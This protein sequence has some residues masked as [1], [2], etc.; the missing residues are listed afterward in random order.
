[1]KEQP[2]KH[3]LKAIKLLQDNAHQ[4]RSIHEQIGS[5]LADIRAQ[6]EA[7]GAE[8]VEFTEEHSRLK[9]RNIELMS[10]Y[11][12]LEA[13][14]VELI[15][16]E[17]SLRYP[18]AVGIYDVLSHED[19]ERVDERIA[20]HIAAFNRKY[21]LEAADY[22]IAGACGLLAILVDLMVARVPQ[23]VT[24]SWTN[25]INERID[26]IIQEAFDKE[27]TAQI[28]DALGRNGPFGSILEQLREGIDSTVK[29][30][31]GSLILGIYCSLDTD[32]NS[33]D[34]SQEDPFLRLGK[35]LGNILV[36]DDTKGRVKSFVP[37]PL[38][39][40]LDNLRMASASGKDFA[41]EIA[42]LE[43]AEGIPGAYLTG[44]NIPLMF[45]ELLLR[46]SYII[47]Q[48]RHHQIPAHTS[49]IETLP[50]SMNPRFRMMLAIAYG[51]PASV[52]GARIYITRDITNANP[53]LWVAFAWNGFFAIK[54]ALLDR[55]L[56]LW[57]SFEAQEIASLE[58][59]VRDMDQLTERASRLP[60]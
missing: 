10:Q 11:S 40:I 34:W 27:T 16:E 47:K 29:S 39:T 54:W 9:Q 12:R 50:Q 20:Q 13:K 49:L 26:S 19:R 5:D 21:G 14:D 31:V 46:A 28:R 48:A 44:N 37:A 17:A 57:K 30:P 53:L 55:H 56:A 8:D 43:E 6:L 60:T 59:L 25:Y 52:N 15:F 1:M 51:V 38:V 3:E 58:K 2:Y 32:Y 45:I 41:V 4:V 24:E 22:A 33:E 36:D 35:A 42:S 7:L 23:E 18:K